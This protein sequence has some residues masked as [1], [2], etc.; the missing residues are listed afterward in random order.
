MISLSDE[1]SNSSLV[2]EVPAAVV[3]AAWHTLPLGNDDVIVVVASSREN[4]GN[5]EVLVL[6]SASGI[7]WLRFVCHCVAPC[8]VV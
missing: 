3:D 4:K 6:V 2:P 7:R 8:S 1:A 5:A